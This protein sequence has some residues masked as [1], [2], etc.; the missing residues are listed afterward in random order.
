MGRKIEFGHEVISD[1]YA[2][3]HLAAAGHRIAILEQ[4][5]RTGRLD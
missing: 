3:I 4:F 1:G 5:A 2:C